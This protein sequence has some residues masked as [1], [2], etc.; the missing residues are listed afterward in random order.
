VG[1]VPFERAKCDKDGQLRSVISLHS[2]S[3]EGELGGRALSSLGLPLFDVFTA[4]TAER[5]VAYIPQGDAPRVLG[6]LASDC[7]DP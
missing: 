3:G 5:E 6:P 2:Y 1:S 4:R 7:A